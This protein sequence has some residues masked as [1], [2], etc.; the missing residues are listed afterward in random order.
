MS[1]D[2]DTNDNKD[3]M[4]ELLE[5]T[6][7]NNKILKKLLSSLRLSRAMRIIYWVIIV[8]VAL[9]AYYYVQPYVEGLIS[10]YNSIGAGVN[11]LNNTLG[12]VNDGIGTGFDVGVQ[13]LGEVEGFLKGLIGQ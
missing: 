2:F 1:V 8:G 9:G 10:T 5:L 7:E 11:S 4:E 13:G 6:K 12:S 3:S